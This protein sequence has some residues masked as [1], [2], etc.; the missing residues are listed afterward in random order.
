VTRNPK[1][2]PTI[3]V[4]CPQVD[5]YVI[6][7]LTKGRHW[8]SQALSSP[9]HFF[10]YPILLCLFII[11]CSP[12]SPDYELQLPEEIS[13]NFDIRPI[14]SNNCYVCHGPD[15]STRQADFRLDL[16]DS[17][18]KRLD[19][20]SKAISP[21]NWQKSVLISRVT[22]SDLEFMMPPPEM[23]RHLSERE[24]ALLKRWIDEGARWEPYWAFMP[25]VEHLVP[26]VNEDQY[27]NNYIDNFVISKLEDHQLTPAKVIDKSGLVRRLAFTLTGLPP[28]TEMVSSFVDDNSPDAY[29]KLVD[30]YLG[31]QHFGEQWARHWMDLVRYAD[32]R[33]HE[34]DYTIIGAWRYRDYLIR[35]FNNDVPY[36]QLIREHLAGDLLENPRL[37]VREGFNESIIGTAFYCLTEGKHSPVDLRLDQSERIDNIID[38]TSKTFQ[39]LTVACAK[40]HD[41]KFD[42]IPTTDYYSLYGM[43]E[44]TRF[45]LNQA[46]F[47]HRKKLILDSLKEGYVNIRNYITENIPETDYS[48]PVSGQTINLQKDYRVI[49]D[50]RNGTLNDW[51]SNG[52]AFVNAL[53]QPVVEGNRVVGLESGKASSKVLG[54][55]LYGVLRS[56]GFVISEDS[57]VI[58]AAGKYSIVRVII[59]NFQLIQDPIYGQLQTI[60]KT[61]ELQD[62]RIDLSM[63]KGHHAYIELLVGD[64]RRRKDKGFHE[65]DLDPQAWVEV[66]YVIAYDSSFTESIAGMKGLK[67]NKLLSELMQAWEEEKATPNEITRLNLWFSNNKP[68]ITGINLWQ[69]NQERRALALYDSSFVVG[70]TDGDHI[71]SPVFLRGSLQN[72]SLEE[73]PHRFLTAVS[74]T[75][76]VFQDK[77]SGRLELAQK[78]ADPKNPLTARVMVNRLW[79]HVFGRGIVETVDNF[80][81]QGKIPSHP[82]LLDYLAIKFIDDGWSVKKLLRYMVLSQT[83][84]RITEPS[85]ASLANDPDNL[86]LQHYPVRRI[87]AESLRD[88]V[89]ATSGRLDKSMYGPPIPMH[90]TEFLEG[91]GR[92]KHSGPIDGAGRRSVYQA[93][94]R[95]FLP[96]MMLAFDMPVPFSTFG[97]RNVSNVP[98]QSLTLL[99]DPFIS[100]QASKWANQ[101]IKEQDSFEERVNKIYMRAF[102]RLALDHE[103]EQARWF[104]AEQQNLL[105][106]EVAFNQMEFELWKS[107]CHTIYNSKEFLFLI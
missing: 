5:C 79:H 67:S 41:H 74:D 106:N 65:Y 63:W 85:Q 95:N 60:P 19:D 72:L 80:G 24:I 73:V 47:D 16:R 25:P 53:G 37:N 59:D 40:C 30:H 100:E 13:F 104:F 26:E 2:K 15:S 32:T 84:Q 23:K 77:G 12:S 88:A 102:S 76:K 62:Y 18:T 103:V 68:F 107:Y 14:L 52:M 28:E 66:E 98:A 55:G 36:D 51:T 38:V 1:Q 48:D 91:R 90:L 50:F 49:G 69:K 20:G 105:E 10:G 78:I 27:V 7:Y 9:P 87:N 71:Q 56:P 58:R 54:K 70:V 81:V 34:F 4:K 75:T 29:E 45:T 21:G 43:I 11:A 3:S 31:S 22:S 96:P 94:N 89:L 46:G 17:A 39:A 83:F 82:Q 35:A 97:R 86:L 61:D 6:R 99:N 101:L 92:P 64:Y 42:P 33:G 57:L 44:S 8:F 93:L